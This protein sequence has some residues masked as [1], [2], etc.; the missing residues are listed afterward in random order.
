MKKK[1]YIIIVFILLLISVSL[2]YTYAIDITIDK[3]ESTST[4]DLTFN[5]NIEENSS[6][7]IS[8]KAGETK[9]FD[10]FITNNNDAT[11]NFSLVYDSIETLKIALS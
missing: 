4:A 10:V 7:T 6:R 3:L 5:I 2:Y 9:Y 1:I 11:I 8:V